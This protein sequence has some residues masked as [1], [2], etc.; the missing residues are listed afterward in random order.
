MSEKQFSF[1]R[2]ATIKVPDQF[3]N[4]LVTGMKAVDIGGLLL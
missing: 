2:A 4:P 1:R 3:F